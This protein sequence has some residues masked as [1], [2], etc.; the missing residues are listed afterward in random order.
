MLRSPPLPRITISS[1][2]VASNLKAAAFGEGYLI[3]AK[4]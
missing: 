1:L 4:T 2:W 3:Y